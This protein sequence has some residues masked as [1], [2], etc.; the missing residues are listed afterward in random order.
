[1][2]SSSGSSPSSKTKA[3]TCEAPLRSLQVCLAT[4]AASPFADRSGN[5]AVGSPQVFLP[6]L[7]KHLGVAHSEATRVLLLHA[8]KEVSRSLQAMCAA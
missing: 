6:A 7:I 1:M 8:L 2:T 4:P 5:L 3:K